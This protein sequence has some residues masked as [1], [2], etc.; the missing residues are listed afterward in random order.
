MHLRNVLVAGVIGAAVVA[1]AASAQTDQVEA[2]PTRNGASVALLRQASHA[3]G[4]EWGGVRGVKVRGTMTDDA[5]SHNFSWLDTWTPDRKLN[6]RTHHDA[7]PAQDVA[8]RSISSDSSGTSIP[9]FN[10]FSS[11]I[12][13]APGAAIR[14]AL[15]DESYQITPSLLPIEDGDSCA[16]ISTPQKGL[17]EGGMLAVICFSK[18]TRMPASVK[19]ALPNRSPGKP[20]LFETITF[21]GFTT[22]NNLVSPSLITITRPGGRQSRIVFEDVDFGTANHDLTEDSPQ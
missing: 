15:Q 18:E 4:E 6:R 11:L 21:D 8:S 10:L 3:L 17:W 9:K 1:H 19:L 14:L 13:H 16:Q 12:G 5:G 7:R 22:R 2:S 20:L